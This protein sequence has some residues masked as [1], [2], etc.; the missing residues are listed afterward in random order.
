MRRSKLIKRRVTCPKVTALA[1]KIK[2]SAQ[3]AR[4]DPSMRLGRQTQ[5]ALAVLANANGRMISQVLRACQLLELST[6]F[7][8]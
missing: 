8:K 7:S 2:Q 4:S 6:Q 1:E 3:R 5:A